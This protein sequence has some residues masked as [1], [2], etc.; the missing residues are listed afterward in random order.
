MLETKTA[1]IRQRA[2]N[3]SAG[4]SRED[5]AQPAMGSQ[6]RSP[7]NRALKWI[8]RSRNSRMIGLSGSPVAGQKLRT[9][10]RLDF[11][12]RNGL[13]NAENCQ[14][15]LIQRCRPQHPI[16]YCTLTVPGNDSFA[17]FPFL[18]HETLRARCGAYSIDSI[19]GETSGPFPNRC[20]PSNSTST[21]ISTAENIPEGFFSSTKNFV[22]TTEL[23]GGGSGVLAFR[24]AGL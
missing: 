16:W 8:A 13:P 17:N 9:R 6:T 14:P 4:H 2:G 15:Q 23:R 22:Q 3:P 12:L 18:L 1:Q 21:I 24:R 7:V 10:V 20:L 5:L 19:P 11:S